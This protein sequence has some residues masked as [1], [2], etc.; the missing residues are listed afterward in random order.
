[1]RATEMLSAFVILLANLVHFSADRQAHLL[2]RR[3]DLA[4]KCIYQGRR[5]P[6][7][8]QDCK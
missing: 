2:A 1:M 7:F 8:I 4:V 5:E 3:I 6:E